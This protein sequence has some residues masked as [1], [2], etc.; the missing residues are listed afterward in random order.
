MASSVQ[1]AI[2]IYNAYAAGCVHAVW[3]LC[4]VVWC[5]CGVCVVVVWCQCGGGCVVFVWCLCG[6]CVVSVWCLCV[7]SVWWLYGVV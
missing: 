3:C 5:L 4:G 2:N 1:L 7:A 6:G